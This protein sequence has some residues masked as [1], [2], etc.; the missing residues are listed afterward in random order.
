MIVTVY[1]GEP[2][3]NFLQ[4]WWFQQQRMWLKSKNCGM[5]VIRSKM[6]IMDLSDEIWMQAH[7]NYEMSKITMI[8]SEEVWMWV[9]QKY[10]MSW[11]VWKLYSVET[12]KRSY[13][14]VYSD[15]WLDWRNN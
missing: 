8:V 5:N 7:Q 4:S 9:H 2:D 10:G 1:T 3:I 11:I 12:N 13:L 14:F 15:G 6:K